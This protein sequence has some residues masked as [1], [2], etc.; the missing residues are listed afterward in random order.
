M[1]ENEAMSIGTAMNVLKPGA[2]VAV[3]VDSET[4]VLQWRKDTM[5]KEADMVIDSVA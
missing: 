4:R 5:T 1:I 2:A 3:L